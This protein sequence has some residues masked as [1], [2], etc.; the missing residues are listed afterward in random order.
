M[1]FELCLLFTVCACVCVALSYAL[2]HERVKRERPCEEMTTKA[3]VTHGQIAAY[4]N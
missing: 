1:Q 2:L 4:G 3:T